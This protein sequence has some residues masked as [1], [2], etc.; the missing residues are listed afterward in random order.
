MLRMKEKREMV[1]TGAAGA[2]TTL[3]VVAIT[4]VEGVMLQ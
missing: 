1:V 3:A 2:M 4:G